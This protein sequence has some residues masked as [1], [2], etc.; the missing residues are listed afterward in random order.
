MNNS[1]ILQDENNNDNNSLSTFLI[2]I[3][4]NGDDNYQDDKKRGKRRSKN[5][6]TGRT[7]VCNICGKA[8]LSYPALY[9]HIKTKH[10]SVGGGSS[11]GRGRPKKDTGDINTMKILYN[12]CNFEYFKHPERIGETKN[13][14][15]CIE[16]VFQELYSQIQSPKFKIYKKINEHPLLSK[17][18]DS[19][20][21]NLPA[22]DPENCKCDDVFF[23]YL[24]KVS[25]MCKDE[26]FYKILKFI[27]LF[28]ECL[29]YINREKTG[30]SEYA[31]ISN[32]EDAPEISN[33]FVTEF[34]ED[35]NQFNYNKEEVIDLTQNLCQYMYDNNFTCSKLSLINI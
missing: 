27:L 14:Q 6:N 15:N 11:R 1:K 29:N 23:E 3:G 10:N 31:D 18:Y 7:Y 9:T 22:L 24:V 21:Y 34:M 32:P 33:E 16:I 26:Y 5:D 12:P 35:E 8:Y 25:K 13:I 4:Q 17:F 19:N 30:N 28:R 20:S 2:N